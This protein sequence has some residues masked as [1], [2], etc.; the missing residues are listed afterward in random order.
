ML[1]DDHI[2]LFQECSCSC[3]RKRYVVV[4]T[5]QWFYKKTAIACNIIM[6]LTISV[7]F[8]MSCFQDH[9]K[10][11]QVYLRMSYGMPSLRCN[12]YC[13]TTAFVIAPHRQ[14]S[15]LVSGVWAG[16]MISNCVVMHVGSADVHKCIPAC[17]VHCLCTPGDLKV[18]ASVLFT[19]CP[20]KQT[21]TYRCD[22]AWDQTK[23]PRWHV[24]QHKVSLFHGM[25]KTLDT[26]VMCHGMLWKLEV[27]FVIACHEQTRICQTMCWCTS[28]RL[29]C[30]QK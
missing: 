16:S 4:H 19:A 28:L 5:T 17:C 23:P 27:S 9:I 24:V 13:M 11:K 8:K 25:P 7:S 18:W 26:L 1:L 10:S 30:N 29:K 3:T 14:D 2:A 6:F 21:G 12:R 15:K 22:I 20:Y